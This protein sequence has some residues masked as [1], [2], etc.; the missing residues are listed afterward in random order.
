[1]YA[2]VCSENPKGGEVWGT[3][4]DSKHLQQPQKEIMISDHCSST[5]FIFDTDVKIYRKRT[6]AAETTA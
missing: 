2:A 1:M 3:S 5:H 4:N 6:Y